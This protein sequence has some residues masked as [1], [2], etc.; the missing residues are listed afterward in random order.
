M[1]HKKVQVQQVTYNGL[2]Y[3]PESSPVL[4]LT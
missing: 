1:F 4:C 3:I 2:S